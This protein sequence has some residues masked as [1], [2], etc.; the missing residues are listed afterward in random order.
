MPDNQIGILT[1]EGDLIIDQSKHAKWLDCVD[2]SDCSYCSKCKYWGSCLDG[3][4][5][6]AKIEA[7]KDS[8]RNICPRTREAVLE[9]ML[10]IEQDCYEF[11]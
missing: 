8:K 2:T 11:L 3:S 7:Y 6:K 9:I 4:C 5:P 10:L 1:E